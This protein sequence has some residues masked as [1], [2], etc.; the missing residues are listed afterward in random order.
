MGYSR[1]VETEEPG[2][3]LE[4]LDRDVEVLGCEPPLARESEEQRVCRGAADDVAPRAVRLVSEPPGDADRALVVAVGAGDGDIRVE[5]REC[6][7][8]HCGP[9]LAADASALMRSGEPGAGPDR[10]KLR[11]R[12][13]FHLL[14]AD[15]LAVEE[16]GE[17]QRPVIDPPGCALGPEVLSEATAEL[18]RRIV[19]PPVCERHHVVAVDPSPCHTGELGDLIVRRRPQLESIRCEP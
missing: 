16:D 8:E 11:K 1:F 15:R 6:E 5:R 18:A 14:D 17:R 9:H 7:V 19:G 3:Q 13:A 12:H 10:A 4:A 2:T